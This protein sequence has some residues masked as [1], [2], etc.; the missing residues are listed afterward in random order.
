MSLNMLARA[1]V[2]AKIDMHDTPLL[3][4]PI[5]CSGSVKVYVDGNFLAETIVRE[6]LPRY[7]VKSNNTLQEILKHFDWPE[8]MKPRFLHHLDILSR[9]SGLDDD[10]SG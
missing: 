4:S 8:D 3:S 1:K 9:L 10:E 2:N 6:N 7:D 5:V